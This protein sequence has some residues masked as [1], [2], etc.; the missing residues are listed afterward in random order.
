MMAW[1]ECYNLLNTEQG[2][3]CKYIESFIGVLMYIH[4]IKSIKSRIVIE[5]LIC[6]MYLKKQKL[7]LQVPCST[8]GP[9]LQSPPCK[10]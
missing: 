8:F 6:L 9:E 7:G 3:S 1:D 2:R 5:K 4:Y 10:C